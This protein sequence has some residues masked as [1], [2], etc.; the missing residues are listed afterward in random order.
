MR[1]KMLMATALLVVA[2]LAS[3]DSVEEDAIE[4]RQ[5]IFKGLSW[6]L[7]PMAEMARNNIPFD[8]D[9]FEHHAKRL[10]QLSL[11]PWEG[12]VDGSYNDG[13]LGEMT[14]ASGDIQHQ[15]AIFERMAASLAT[16][17][18]VLTQVA[19][20]SDASE[21]A[22]IQQFARTAQTCRSCHDDYRER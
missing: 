20:D 1:I 2:P 6:H 14:G 9:A 7:G 16:E 18:G 8:R 5:S 4:Y 22:L 11:M 15:G 10:Y 21:R 19:G 13:P 17:A 3:A 12:F